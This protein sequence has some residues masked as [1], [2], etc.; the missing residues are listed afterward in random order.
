MSNL[1]YEI[2]REQQ[3]IEY[4]KQ[5]DIDTVTELRRIYSKSADKLYEQILKWAAKYAGDHGITI[6]E[7]M[8]VADTAD[9]KALSIAAEKY[10]AEKDFSTEANREMREYNFSMKMSRA[11]YLRREIELELAKLADAETKTTTEYLL[12]NAEEELV[13]QSGILGGTL[14]DAREM[15]RLSEV[16]VNADFHG[17]RFSER[18]WKNQEG[19][20]KVLDEEL[21]RML[22]EG[23]NPRNF[24]S[25]LQKFLKEQM[26]PQVIGSKR[27]QNALYNAERLAITEASRVQTEAQLASYR[28]AGYD[29]YTYIAE[30][31][32]CDICAALN[33]NVYKIEEAQSGTNRPPM[34]PWCK[35]S[36]AAAISNDDTE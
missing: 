3:H 8:K 4:L 10:V 25:R 35:C 23:T 33:G 1:R 17:V 14:M 30:I 28:A 19:L 20:L 29:S 13:R 32:A 16:I 21:G 7:A 26:D 12:T 9:I 15:S 36:T 27:N 24:T 34:H 5:K 2:R 6:E 22:L 31:T 11:E 18:I